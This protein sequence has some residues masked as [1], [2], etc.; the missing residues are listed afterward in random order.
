MGYYVKLKS[1]G[2]SI[3]TFLSDTAQRL[4]DNARILYN[5]VSAQSTPGQ[6]IIAVYPNDGSDIAVTGTVA[7][8]GTFQKAIAG[9]K[10]KP[11]LELGKAKDS[12]IFVNMIQGLALFE[13]VP[14]SN[15]KDKYYNIRDKVEGQSVHLVSTN[16][17]NKQKYLSEYYDWRRLPSF[18]PKV[19]LKTDEERVKRDQDDQTFDRLFEDYV[20][21]NLLRYDDTNINSPQFNYAQVG[22]TSF[23]SNGKEYMPNG[24]NKEKRTYGDIVLDTLGRAKITSDTPITDIRSYAETVEILKDYITGKRRVDMTSLNR[25]Y[26]TRLTYVEKSFLSTDLFHDD[27]HKYDMGKAIFRG[28]LNIQRDLHA[29]KDFLDVID[30][31][32]ARVGKLTE[33]YDSLIKNLDFLIK[34][35]LTGFVTIDSIDVLFDNTKAANLNRPFV[36]TQLSA[37][38]MTI[39]WNEKYSEIVDSKFDDL[40]R[41]KGFV[42]EIS[43]TLKMFG[44][45]QSK[46]ENPS[47]TDSVASAIFAEKLKNYQEQIKPFMK[48]KVSI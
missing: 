24:E 16:S 47:E 8:D 18:V 31:E 17:F 28:S 6:T 36:I 22:I 42:Y 9:C 19:A 20:S 10:V 5:R 4:F 46:S 35:A 3:D 7:A 2:K 15:N 43:D 1:K 27:Y 11:S 48:S 29:L 14:L 30:R 32:L 41:E 21:L 37:F 33:T 40:C 44:D 23:D 12:I 13:S 38:L 25:T 39:N 45:K 34:A 26:G